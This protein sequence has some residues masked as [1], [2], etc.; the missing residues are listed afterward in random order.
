MN[1]SFTK[2]LYEEHHALRRSPGF[3][4]LK[5]ER[6]SLFSDL[7]GKGKRVLDLGCRDG[8][9]TRLFMMGNTVFGV[10]VDANALSRASQIGIKTVE[11]DL[12]GSWS[13]I[14]GE[15]FDAI[16]A[17]EVLEHL[18]YPVKVV[19]K[20][21]NH[22]TAKGIFVGAVPNAF[23]LKNRFR[24]LFNRKKFTPL[25]DPTHINHFSSSEIYTILNSKFNKVSILGLGRHKFLARVCPNLFAFDLMFVAQNDVK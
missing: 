11:M 8:A 4:I 25:S 1:K 20:I 12:Y 17:G 24:Y 2:E 10:D 6:G 3:S 15:E 9:L 16:V 22:L 14:A 23:S 7:I 13:E 5:K 18:Y 21:A 19:E